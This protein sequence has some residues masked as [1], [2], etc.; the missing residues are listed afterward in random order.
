MNASGELVDGVI[1]AGPTRGRGPNPGAAGPATRNEMPIPGRA[2]VALQECLDPPATT[3]S[4]IVLGPQV[5]RDLPRQFARFVV[6]PPPGVAHLARVRAPDARVRSATCSAGR[7][8]L[9]AW[10]GGAPCDLERV[11]KD[12]TV[13]P[14]QPL[15]PRFADA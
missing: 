5:V 7:L 10:P 13:R 12:K 8:Q 14:E 9:Q 2:G 6:P 15:E 11:G 4:E 1:G 3:A